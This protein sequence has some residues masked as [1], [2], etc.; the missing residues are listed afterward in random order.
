M[1]KSVWI[2]L[3][4]VFAVS[5]AGFI[6]T[7]VQPRYPAAVVSV[8]RARSVTTHGK[9]GSRSHTVI[10]L[11][12]TYT[13]SGGGKQTVDVNYPWPGEQMVPGREIMI[14]RSFDGFTV[15][16]FRGLRMFTG[17]VCGMLGL[18][19]LFTRMDG[20]NRKGQGKIHR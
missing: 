16:P 19:I 20:E 12:V 5:A 7:F 15:Y 18:F 9:H 2:V 4:A 6:Y 3:M 13:D 8:G 10:P 1:K 17:V 11:T 14:V